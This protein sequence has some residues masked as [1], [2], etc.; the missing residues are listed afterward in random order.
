MKQ[1][2][3]LVLLISRTRK[4]QIGCQNVVHTIAPLDSRDPEEAQTKQ[5]GHYQQNRAECHFQPDKPFARPKP[6]TP[7]RCGAR[8]EP[9]RVGRLYTSCAD[10]RPQAAQDATPRR[11]TE[12]EQQRSQTNVH[13]IKPR[14][15]DRSGVRQD[16]YSGVRQQYA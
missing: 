6:S 5:G 10:R 7:F 8:A 2:A 3:L 12:R 13:F 11:Y 1:G 9:K 14:N 4:G 15:V 16:S